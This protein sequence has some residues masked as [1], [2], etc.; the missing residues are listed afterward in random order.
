LLEP[1]GP[2]RTEAPI[3][4]QNGIGTIESLGHCKP[5]PLST[6]KNEKP[7]K[8]NLMANDR[9]TGVTVT[10]WNACYESG[11]DVIVLAC[12]ATTTDSSASITSVG[13]ILN[14]SAGTTLAS[15][16]TELSNGSESATPALNLPPGGLQ[17]GDTVM[18]VLTG[19]AG[20]QH[21]F[22]EQELVIGTC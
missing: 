10:S 15:T 9:N 4:I 21:F 1:D 19:E 5:V 16:Y 2:V 18:G 17:V 11:D 22:F 8:G 6:N 7:S 3:S 12:T 13:L 14:N 20:G